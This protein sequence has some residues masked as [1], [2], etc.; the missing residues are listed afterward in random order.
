MDDFGY[1]VIAMG[2][3]ILIALF[4]IWGIIEV[5]PEQIKKGKMFELESNIYICKQVKEE[6]EK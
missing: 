4:F 6:K 3:F 1:G 2:A 5:N